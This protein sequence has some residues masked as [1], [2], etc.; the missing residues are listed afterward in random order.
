MRVH[1]E[2]ELNQP[3]TQPKLD[4]ALGTALNQHAVRTEHAPL[5]AHQCCRRHT[6]AEQK[7]IGHMYSV[8]APPLRLQPLVAQCTA[9]TST[10]NPARAGKPIN[11]FMS[12][13]PA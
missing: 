7:L 8:T 13:A 2:V 6:T 11:C 1:A 5:A 12:L 9:N 10:G 3:S 4:Q